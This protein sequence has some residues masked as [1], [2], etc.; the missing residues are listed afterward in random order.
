MDYN[1]NQLDYADGRAEVKNKKPLM[2]RRKGWPGFVHGYNDWL[3][4]K[5]YENVKWNK[6]PQQSG[7]KSVKKE[8]GKIIYTF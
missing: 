4:S 7:A 6:D 2:R 3:K 8:N 5:G 1:S